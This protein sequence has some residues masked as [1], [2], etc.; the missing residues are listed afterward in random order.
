MCLDHKGVLVADFV[1]RGTTENVGS[2]SVTLLLI[3]AARQKSSVQC[4]RD[5]SPAALPVG[6][7]G[8]FG[9]KR[10]PSTECLISVFC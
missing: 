5:S 7:H 3:R 4:Q 2:F 9:V 1:Q 6:N 8:K 10:C